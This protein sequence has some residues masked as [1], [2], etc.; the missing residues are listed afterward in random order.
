MSA[1]CRLF[2][3]AFPADNLKKYNKFSKVLKDAK[4]FEGIYPNLNFTITNLS[5][6]GLINDEYE[7]LQYVLS[8]VLQLNQKVIKYLL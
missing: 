8:M 1:I 2:Q 4:V 3:K 5:N 6:W 7:T